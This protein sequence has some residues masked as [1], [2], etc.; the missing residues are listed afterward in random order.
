MAKTVGA[1]SA[2]VAILNDTDET[3][4]TKITQLTLVPLV[5]LRLMLL[6]QKV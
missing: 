1:D 4:N 6:H 3:V 2:R 5:F